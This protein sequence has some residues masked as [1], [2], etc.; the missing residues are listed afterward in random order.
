MR[1]SPRREILIS[2]TEQKYE[3]SLCRKENK[4]T[5]QSLEYRLSAALVAVRWSLSSLLLLSSLVV[6][7]AVAVACF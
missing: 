3:T 6:S 5:K 4:I 1:I 2:I 7:F